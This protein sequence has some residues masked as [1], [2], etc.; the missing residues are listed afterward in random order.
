M[1]IISGHHFWLQQSRN[2][3]C[4]WSSHP[5]KS[6]TATHNLATIYGF[7]DLAT[8]STPNKL[9]TIYGLKNPATIPKTNKWF[10]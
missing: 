8:I 10:W 6:P 4:F 1:A 9:T 3:I 5:S 2:N 7:N